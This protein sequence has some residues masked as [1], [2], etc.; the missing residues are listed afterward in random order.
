MIEK[1]GVPKKIS[2]LMFARDNF[3]E[4]LTNTLDSDYSLKKIIMEM[5]KRGD[6]LKI[7]ESFQTR[8]S[9]EYV[10]DVREDNGKKGSF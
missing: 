5:S 1:E 2:E 9:G 7:L 6:T 10:I 4:F 8:N 3:D